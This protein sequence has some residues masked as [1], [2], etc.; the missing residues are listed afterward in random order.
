MAAAE[1]T[2]IAA[3]RFEERIA[4]GIAQVKGLPKDTAEVAEQPSRIGIRLEQA[5]Q[6]LFLSTTAGSL[7]ESRMGAKS[8]CLVNSS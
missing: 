2:S 4:E 1:D 8:W 7:V 5:L 6:Q 3:D